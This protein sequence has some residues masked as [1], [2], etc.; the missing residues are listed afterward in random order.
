VRKLATAESLAGL[1]GLG[2]VALGV[3]GF[4]PGVVQDYGAL[5]WWK[6]R[7]AAE[8]FDV[9]QTSILLNLVH[10]GFGVAGLLAARRSATARAYLTGGGAALF[11]L[12][13]YGLLVDYT[14]EWN[15]LPFDRADEW[16]HIGLGIGMLY[17]GLAVGLA[18]LRPVTSA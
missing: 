18:R 13:V 8:L 11:V 5:Q 17:A 3:L 4:I 2:L 15:F 1:S 12:G 10:I 7:S 9:F 16:L 6:S 14:S